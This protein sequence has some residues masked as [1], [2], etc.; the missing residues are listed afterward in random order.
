MAGGEGPRDRGRMQRPHS[1]SRRGRTVTASPEMC[2]VVGEGVIADAIRSHCAD[3]PRQDAVGALCKRDD[4]GACT[5][6]SCWRGTTQPPHRHGLTPTC[7][8]RPLK[9][10]IRRHGALGGP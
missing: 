1:T 9:T 10:V 3:G 2:G 4:D 7:W 5:G 6:E 8:G